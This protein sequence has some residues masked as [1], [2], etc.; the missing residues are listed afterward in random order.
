LLNS[1]ERDFREQ[2]RTRRKVGRSV[3]SATVSLDAV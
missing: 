2:I 3:M 1:V